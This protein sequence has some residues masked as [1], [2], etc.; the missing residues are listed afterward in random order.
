MKKQNKIMLSIGALAALA[1]PTAIA[2]TTLTNKETK[3]NTFEKQTFTQYSTMS[4]VNVDSQSMYANPVDKPLYATDLFKAA[5][6]ALDNLNDTKEEVQDLEKDIKKIE[7]DMKDPK[8]S[9]KL[10]ML[11]E[12]LTIAKAKKA[13]VLEEQKKEQIAY[14]TAIADAWQKEIAKRFQAKF[15]NARMSEK[16]QNYRKTS[17]IVGDIHK[18]Q[19][20]SDKLKAFKETTGIELPEFQHGIRVKSLNLLSD[21]NGTLTVTIVLFSETTSKIYEVHG[22]VIGFNNET[23]TNHNQP[24]NL[25]LI[26]SKFKDVKVKKT[27]QKK[28]S[29][30]EKDINGLSGIEAKLNSFERMT[31][32]HLDPVIHGTEITGIDLRSNKDGELTVLFITNTPYATTPDLTAK[33]VIQTLTDKKID[34]IREKKRQEIER[35]K[36]AAMPP[37]DHSKEDR[38]RF[39]AIVASASAGGLL[40]LILGIKLMVNMFRK[41][42]AKKAFKKEQ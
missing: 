16:G 14:D 23:V 24:R 37:V 4:S 41:R 29:E 20:M 2:A 38:Q 3:N 10:K 27:I 8:N 42:S 17:D 33:V 30:I 15:Q 9:G 11:K 25:N 13:K 31:G 1:I 32:V 7:A 22:D 5:A 36:R 18:L 28:A 6:T 40:V 39:I 19:K 35:Q 12:A 21:I 26:A 34:E